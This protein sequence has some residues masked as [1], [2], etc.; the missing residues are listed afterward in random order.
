MALGLGWESYII[1]NKSYIDVCASYEVNFFGNQN[2]LRSF[3]DALQTN[4]SESPEDL[5]FH[6]LTVSATV[7]F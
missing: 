3:K 5:T 1:N 6:G 4:S 2:T 7:H